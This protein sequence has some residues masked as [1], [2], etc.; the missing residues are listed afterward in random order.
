MDFKGL[1]GLSGVIWTLKGSVDSGK[2]GGFWGLCGLS[3]VV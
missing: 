3:G 1:C 2:L